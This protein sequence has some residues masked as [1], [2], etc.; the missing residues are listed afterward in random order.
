MEVIGRRDVLAA[1]GSAGVGIAGRVA[2]AEG[3]FGVTD[4]VAP[5]PLAAETPEHDPMRPGFRHDLE[6]AQAVV[7]A[8]H[9]NFDRVRELVLQQP[10]LAKASWD[11]GFGDWESALGA[12][13]HTGRREIAE[14]LIGHGARPTIFSAAMLGEL[15]VVRAHVVAR[16]ETAMIHGPHG[17][18]LVRHARAGRE[19]AELVVEYLLERIGPDETEMGV[20]TNEEL[21]ER[22]AGRYVDPSA[23]D[24]VLTVAAERFLTIGP[25]ETAYSRV[26]PVSEDVFHPTGAPDVRVAFDVVD[27]RARSVAITDGP[28]RWVLVRA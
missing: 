2:A 1:L 15:D 11:W 8:S 28:D 25:G 21:A 20:G 14:F 5:A 3:L 17:I 24:V 26:L 9:G 23:R 18:S 13:A 16:P 19:Q 22:Y 4:L 27:G 12:A 10:A 6:R 7:G